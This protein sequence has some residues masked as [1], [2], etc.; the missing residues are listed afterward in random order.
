MWLDKGVEVLE[1][2]EEISEL[3]LEQEI[4][5]INDVKVSCDAARQRA[6][7]LSQNSVINCCSILFLQHLNIRKVRKY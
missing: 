3:V 1:D 5:S 6:F 2:G 4:S 7:Q